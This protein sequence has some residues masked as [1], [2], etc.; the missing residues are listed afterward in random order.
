MP[1]QYFSHR[2]GTNRL[3]NRSKSEDEI[4]AHRAISS[5]VMCVRVRVC[6]CVVVASKKAVSDPAG[7]RI[8]SHASVGMSVAGI[9]VS[10]VVM[11][12]LIAVYAVGG[13]NHSSYSSYSYSYP[14]FRKQY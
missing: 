8:L 1:G 14:S 12:V 5:H 7:A 2:W 10:V 13:G 3:F 4:S 6:A 9:V 11:I